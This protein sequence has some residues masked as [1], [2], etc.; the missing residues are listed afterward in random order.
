MTGATPT[1]SPRMEDFA[2][3]AGLARYSAVR[4]EAF[5]VSGGQTSRLSIGECDNLAKA[6]VAAQPALLHREHL[7]V[8]EE[9]E[10]T[11]AVRLHVYTVR[12]KPAQWVRLAGDHMPQRVRELWCDPV[13][14]IDGSVVG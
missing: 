12:Q 5:R 2:A 3:A 10:T 1:P 11:G 9:N 7:L 6:V 13:C 14:V 8:R 4:F